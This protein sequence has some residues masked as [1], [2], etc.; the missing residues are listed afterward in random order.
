MQ[1]CL[2]TNPITPSLCLKL[3]NCFNVVSQPAL[4]RFPAPVAAV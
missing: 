2:R 3:P 4:S 1:S